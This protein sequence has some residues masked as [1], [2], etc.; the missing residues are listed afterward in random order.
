[1]QKTIAEKTKIYIKNF[2]K[3]CKSIN[4][5]TIIKIII[6]VMIDYSEILNSCFS[7]FKDNKSRKYFLITF[8]GLFLINIVFQAIGL[9]ASY[10]F[11]TSNLGLSNYSSYQTF[12]NFFTSIFTAFA[13]FIALA[14][15]FVIIQ[16]FVVK[17]FEGR[18]IKNALEFKGIK[19]PDFNFNKFLKFC[20]L[21]I[22]V[23]FVAVASW[24]NKIFFVIFL[25]AVLLSVIGVALTIFMK[26]F[27]FIGTI[28]LFLASVIFFVYFIVVLY[29]FLRLALSNVH[30]ISNDVSIT[31]T[32]K[33]IW[34]LTSGKVCHF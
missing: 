4:L 27:L 31:N 13:F 11:G 1:V 15:I 21:Q 19:V 23:F 3:T 16:F 26:G 33:E 24:H 17:Y 2:Y 29:N 18:I 28:V 20:M 22:W 10:N 5:I 32:T 7:W 12:E 25:L 30:F 8:A 34:N 9:G 14:L 6:K